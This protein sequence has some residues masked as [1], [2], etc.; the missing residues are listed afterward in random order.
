MITDFLS[1]TFQFSNDNTVTDNQLLECNKTKNSKAFCYQ[2]LVIV[3]VTLSDQSD[4]QML[5]VN[6]KYDMKV[7]VYVFVA[8]DL[9][10]E[11]NISIQ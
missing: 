5:Q 11:L 10:P 2:L 8:N 3:E 1:L 9:L 4:L 6:D 7:S